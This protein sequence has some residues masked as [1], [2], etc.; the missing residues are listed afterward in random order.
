MKALKGHVTPAHALNLWISMYLGWLILVLGKKLS[1]HTR[2]SF[3]SSS[4]E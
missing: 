1:S 3:W 4:F 2:T